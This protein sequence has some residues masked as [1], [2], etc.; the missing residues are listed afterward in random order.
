MSLVNDA[1]SQQAHRPTQR[2]SSGPARRRT[3]RASDWWTF[4]LAVLGRHCWEKHMLRA[5]MEDKTKKKNMMMCPHDSNCEAATLPSF[6]KIHVTEA[7][8]SRHQGRSAG[9]VDARCRCRCLLLPP[10][11]CCTLGR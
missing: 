11:P 5:E 3:D 1:M 7:E 8:E 6:S 10:P 9:A 4:G 2:Q